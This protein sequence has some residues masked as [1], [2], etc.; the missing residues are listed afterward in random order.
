MKQTNLFA[1]LFTLLSYSVFAQDS[2]KFGVEYFGNE[3]YSK[4]PGA[5][6]VWIKNNNPI[7]A[8]I[9]FY[10]GAEPDEEGFL[11]VVPRKAFGWKNDISF[12]VTGRE[13]DQIGFTHIRCQLT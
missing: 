11:G 10:Q 6:H 13:E 4:I 12:I 7:P 8:F 1:L 5:K 3:A 9:E 2:G